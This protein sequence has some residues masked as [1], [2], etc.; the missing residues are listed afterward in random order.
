MV[1]TY[2]GLY[3]LKHE[4]KMFSVPPKYSSNF[5]TVNK[6]RKSIG[7]RT[8]KKIQMHDLIITYGNNFKDYHTD[9][10]TSRNLAL[11]ESGLCF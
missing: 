8:Q 5:K 1:K 10:H 4:C 11:E 9:H 3:E 2:F 7:F 6:F